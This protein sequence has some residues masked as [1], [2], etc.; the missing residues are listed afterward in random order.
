M[1]KHL[2]RSTWQPVCSNELFCFPVNFTNLRKPCGRFVVTQS[3]NPRKLAE[4]VVTDT[5]L[6]RSFAEEWADG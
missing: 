3:K 4:A 5:R 1:D 6:R 2:F